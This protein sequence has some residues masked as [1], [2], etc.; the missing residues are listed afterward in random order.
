MC[1]FIVDKESFIEKF[2]SN[3]LLYLTFLEGHVQITTGDFVLIINYDNSN[4]VS[5]GIPG[6][7]MIMR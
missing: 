5:G 3:I 7:M 1:T 2:S 4:D 6:V